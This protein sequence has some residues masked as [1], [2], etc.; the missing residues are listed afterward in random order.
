MRRKKTQAPGAV[1]FNRLPIGQAFRFA[2]EWDFP[3]MKTGVAIKTS[4]A[5]YRY[6]DGMECTVGSKKVLVVEESAHGGV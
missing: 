4:K 5:C 2:S 1:E 3:G 6:L